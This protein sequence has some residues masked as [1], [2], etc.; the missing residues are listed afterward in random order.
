VKLHLDRP[1]ATNLIAAFDHGYV[2]INQTRHT[3]SVIVLTDRVIE[4]WPPRAFEQISESD[5]DALAQLGADIVLLG[6]GRKQRFPH[7]RLSSRL[8]SRRIGLEVMDTAAACRT[9]NILA[10]EMR[11]VAAALILE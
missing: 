6:T 1:G 11:N 5:F 4:A 3:A 7:P 8:L 10:G 2:Q 9:Y